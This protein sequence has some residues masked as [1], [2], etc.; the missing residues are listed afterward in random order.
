MIDILRWANFYGP[1]NEKNG[2]NSL[3]SDVYDRLLSDIVSQELPPDSRIVVDKLARDYEVSQTPIRQALARLQADSLVLSKPNSG[4]RVAPLPSKEW[5]L[6]SLEYRLIVEP[7]ATR[8]AAQHMTTLRE[9]ML[10]NVLAQLDACKSGGAKSYGQFSAVDSVFHGLIAKYSENDVIFDSLSNVRRRMIGFRMTF[11]D[12]FRHS[13]QIEH[14]KIVDA[15]LNRN[16]DAAF[17]AMYDHI[18]STIQWMH[19]T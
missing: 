3:G 6:S 15:L 4:F 8:L 18:T 1:M 2:L 16:P 13:L 5:F 11:P 7:A 17:A 10:R 9:G 12:D 19:R 14:R